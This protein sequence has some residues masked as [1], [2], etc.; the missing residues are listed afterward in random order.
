[1]EF[2]ISQGSE[3]TLVWDL[4]MV[5]CDFTEVIFNTEPLRNASVFILK[6]TPY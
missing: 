5:Y 1:M 3:N 6:V 2:G 4:V